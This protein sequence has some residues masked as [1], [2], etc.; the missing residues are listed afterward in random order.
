MV[1]RELLLNNYEWM[2]GDNCLMMLYQNRFGGD[3]SFLKS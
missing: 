3:M 1:L 2:S